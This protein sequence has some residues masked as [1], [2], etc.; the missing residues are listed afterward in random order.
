MVDLQSSR[1][2]GSAQGP[3]SPND[4]REC[5]RRVALLNRVQ[6]RRPHGCRATPMGHGPHHPCSSS[7]WIGARSPL[8]ALANV[9]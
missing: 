7:S 9:W 1:E 3:P 5:N 2:A 4:R 6:G 8:P